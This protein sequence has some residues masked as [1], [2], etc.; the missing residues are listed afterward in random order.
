MKTYR[1]VQDGTLVGDSASL[2]YI[3]RRYSLTKEAVRR[4]LGATGS[5]TIFDAIGARFIIVSAND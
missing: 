1:I 2:S 5:V 4:I 3:T